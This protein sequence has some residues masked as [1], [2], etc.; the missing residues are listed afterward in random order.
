M[1]FSTRARYGLRMM[2]EF[3]RELI[4]DDI[5]HLGRI[6]KITGLSEN[7]LAQ[8]TSPLKGAGLLIGVS[9]KKGG[10][11]LGR[12]AEQIRVGEIIEALIGSIGVT[13]CVK[14][15]D[16]CM[17]ASFCEA[18]MIWAL[19]SHSMQKAFNRFS[20]A[21]L[22]NRE[23]MV[24]IMKESSDISLFDPD[25]V[26]VRNIEAGKYGQNLKTDR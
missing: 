1:K 3:A 8:L 11:M 7:Y 19:A 4:K 18:R 2:I 17:N 15:S 16:L 25:G 22:V 20:L 9:G 10:Y 5:V 24:E 12:P 14:S 21:D 26:M 6:A 23:R 13:D